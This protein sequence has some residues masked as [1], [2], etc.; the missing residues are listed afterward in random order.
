MDREFEVTIKSGHVCVD[1]VLSS[2]AKVT[3]PP[4]IDELP[5]TELG[6]YAMAGSGVEEVYLPPRIVRIGAYAF[7]NCEKLAAIHAFGRALDLGAGVFAG[8]KKIALLDLYEYPGEASCLKDLLSE[9]RQTLRVRLHELEGEVDDP[10]DCALRPG[11]E[12]RLVFPEFF[13][14]SIENTPARQLIYQMHGCGQRYRYSFVNREFKFAEYDDL[15]PHAKN[16]ADEEVAA[17]L[18]IGRLRFPRELGDNARAAYEDYL[19]S[20]YKAAARILIAADECESVTTTNLEPETLPWL[21]EEIVKPDGEQLAFV[22]ELA[23]RYGDTAMVSY[24]MDLS[25]RN[26]QA[27]GAKKPR[28]RR[29]E[30]T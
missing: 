29:F 19:R 1:K 17:E 20:N 12:A 26:R 2:A 8:D 27:P 15:F 16:E 23:R 6:S 21:L 7:Y 10:E 30:L 25:H 14:E 3:I 13:E 11:T 9:I 5:V 18:A 28:A 24:C 22:T 4:F